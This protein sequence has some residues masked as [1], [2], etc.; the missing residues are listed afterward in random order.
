MSSGK[1]ITN[2]FSGELR[3]PRGSL[4]TSVLGLN[5]LENVRRRD[6]GEVERRVLPQQ[7]HVDG[8]KI[9]ELRLAEARVIALDVLDR[10][11]L[12]H[13]LDALAVEPQPVGRVVQDAVAARLGFEKKREGRVAGDADALDRVHLHGDGQGHGRPVGRRAAL[14][15]I[16]RSRAYTRPARGGEAARAR[17]RRRRPAGSGPPPMGFA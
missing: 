8:R 11:R 17:R 6:I 12:R 7:H 10:Q 13:R 5:A 3:T 1:S 9:D 14:Q 4:T 2:S 16:S 15:G